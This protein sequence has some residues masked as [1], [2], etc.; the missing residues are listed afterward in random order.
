[1]YSRSA[2]GGKETKMEDGDVVDADD[3]DVVVCNVVDE[4]LLFASAGLNS[5]K[6]R[7]TIKAGIEDGWCWYIPAAICNVVSSFLVLMEFS[8]FSFVQKQKLA[9]GRF[10][11]GMYEYRVC[12]VICCACICLQT[13]AAH[14]DIRI[15][16]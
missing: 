7:K 13:F 9:L 2:P 10:E 14:E 1:M 15:M 5:M 16:K 6:V 11:G 4:G 3:L 12:N 8:K